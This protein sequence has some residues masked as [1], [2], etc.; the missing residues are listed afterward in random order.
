MEMASENRLAILLNLQHNDYRLSELS[1]KVDSTAQEVYRNLNRLMKSKMIEKTNENTY[2]ITN[3]GKA[4]INMT[5]IPAFLHKYRS[6]FDDHSFDNLPLKFIHRIGAL[7]DCQLIT[8]VTNVIDK[9]GYLYANSDEYLYDAVSESLEEFDE[10]IISKIS[11]KVPYYHLIPKD[12]T[13]QNGRI[14]KLKQNG[15]Y[16]ALSEGIIKR[17]MIPSLNF[18]LIINEDEA[19][20]IF[21]AEDGKPDLRA[22]F[23][24]NTTQF[25][26]WCTDLFNYNW[27]KAKKYPHYQVLK[28]LN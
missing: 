28:K 23:Y 16:E 12:H 21:P 1:E 22:M 6:F 8:G 19:A 18:A 13:E 4:L 2:R 5:S 26:N 3:I 11:H 10:V 20:V 17:K 27:K 14:K 15:Y 7:E 24:G 9:I 25:H